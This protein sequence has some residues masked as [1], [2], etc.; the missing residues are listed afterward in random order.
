MAGGRWLSIGVLLG[1]LAP[2]Q[3][4]DAA[5]VPVPTVAAPA[6][7]EAPTV[8]ETIVVTARKREEDGQKVPLA[9]SIVSGDT[10]AERRLESI[11]DLSTQVPNLETVTTSRTV[12]LR[13]VGGGGRHVAFDTRASVHVDG[14]YVGAPPASDSL[15]LDL[16][17]V[18]VLRGPQGTLFGQ[19]STSGTLNLVTR[20]PDAARHAQL[21]TG[22]GSRDGREVAG[23]L[24]LPLVADSLLLRLSGSGRWRDGFT[25]NRTI[26]GQNDDVDQVGGRLRLRWLPRAGLTIDLSADQ[27]RDATRN[28]AGEPLTSTFGNA[29]PESPQRFV[30]DNDT[31][32]HDVNRN[33]GVSGTV[34]VETSRG[35]FT[36]ISAWRRAERDQL[37]DFDRSS[38]D[39]AIYDYRDDFNYLSQE[40]RFASAPGRLQYVAGLYFLQVQG[41]SLRL[42]TAGPQIVTGPPPFGSIVPGDR[43]TTRPD[44]ESRSIA[45]FGSVDYAIT[46]RVVANAGLRVT[47]S[48]KEGRF[49]QTAES[50]TIARVAN[51]SGFEDDFDETSVDPAIGLQWFAADEGMAYA[52][53]AR[54]TKSG[55]FNLDVLSSP[56][57]FPERF[58]EETVTNYEIGFKQDFLARRLRADIALF[59]ADYRDYQVTQ[60]VQV[61]DIRYPGM[62]NAGRVRT[63]GPELTLDALPLPGLR[64]G[65]TAAWLHAE[66][67]SF[68]DAEGIGVDYSGNRTEYAPRFN[69]S[70]SLRYERRVPWRG[71]ERWF[72]DAVL[73]GRTRSFAEAS[74][75]DRFEID[76]H[77]LLNAQAGLIQATDR[78]QINLWAENL[79]DERYE[80]TR[81]TGTFGTL[82]GQHGTPRTGGLQ[83]TYRW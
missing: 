47:T 24:N 77:T 55:G 1:M 67:A 37:A 65:L 42:A 46:D 71:S 7:A 52:R 74:N 20:A 5:A 35:R 81:S 27:T 50:F 22:V 2:V 29:P 70:A 83:V 6:A 10:L 23:S 63:W 36:A 38:A 30:V 34:N 80:R 48:R 61:G 69:G 73:S 9:L 64:L 16:D 32:E 41:D 51:L 56:R 31:P 78:W 53:I 3:A 49:D 39:F 60:T 17:R 62:T 26:G 13:G 79:L 33:A 72:V 40:L 59:Y 11:A 43:I 4:Q 57:P 44:L 82:S 18:E 21:V 58:D 28:I 66:Y 68:K 12:Y 54:G 15:L 25:R 75:A 14:V 19:N 45:A 76:G 8:L